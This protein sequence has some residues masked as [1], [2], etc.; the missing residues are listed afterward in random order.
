MA[1]CKLLIPGNIKIETKGFMRLVL[2]IG[3]VNKDGGYEIAYT[4]Y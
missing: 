1:L 3:S 4:N 2:V